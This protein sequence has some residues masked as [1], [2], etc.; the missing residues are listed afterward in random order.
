LQHNEKIKGNGKIHAFI[1][2]IE[3]I[4][5]FEKVEAVQN[6]VTGQIRD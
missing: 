1:L 2:L 4:F 5:G 6:W 3:S